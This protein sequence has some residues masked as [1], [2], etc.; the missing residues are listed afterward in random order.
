M[1]VIDAVTGLEVSIWINGQPGK[2]FEDAS[3]EVDGPLAS[4]TVVKYIEA[5]S[6]T[7]FGVK[8][9]VLPTFEEHRQ[10]EDDLVVLAKVDGKWSAGRFMAFGRSD[11]RPWNALL[12]GISGVDETGKGT[13]RPF[14][15]AVVNIVEASDIGQTEIDMKTAA[16]LGE[17]IVNVF[18]VKIGEDV[19]SRY[20][21]PEDVATSIS[22]KV[23]KGRALSHGTAFGPA[24]AAPPRR[25]SA[26]EYVDAADKPLARFIFRYRSKDALCKL[27]IIERS[28]SIDLFDSLPAAE[29]E[30]LAREA[31][32]WQQSPKP[33]TGI[34][35]ER[36]VKRERR[37]SD[38]MDLTGD[39]PVAK[40]RKTTMETPIDLTDG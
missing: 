23:I 21:T 19:P 4:K 12:G 6:D 26:F 33:E 28:P 35:P 16:N 8:V 11:T 9:S 29:R 27:L 1:A 5:I 25:T 13:L 30:R 24:K 22:E 31:F 36:M 37:D 10:T 34:K 3:E 7:E 17:V 38:I 20:T 32:Q 39:A 2:E 15:F 40:Q 18:R 14:R